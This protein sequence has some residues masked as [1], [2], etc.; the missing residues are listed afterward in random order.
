MT[1]RLNT[2]ALEAHLTLALL[3]AQGVVYHLTDPRHRSLLYAAVHGAASLF[4]AVSV[5]RH[6]E[7]PEDGLREH[8][9]ELAA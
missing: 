3:H 9:R 6:M 2:L 1:N 8:Y 5:V 4:S 7:T